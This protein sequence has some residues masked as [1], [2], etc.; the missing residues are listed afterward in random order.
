M[1][2]SLMTAISYVDS[3]VKA[4]DLSEPLMGYMEREEREGRSNCT[5]D[6]KGM[7]ADERS[8]VQDWEPFMEG[9][10]KVAQ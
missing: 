10:K 5:R 7:V 4:A 2:K 3:N 9:R 8:L 6:E 1:V